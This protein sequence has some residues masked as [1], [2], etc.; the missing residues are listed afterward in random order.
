MS[1]DA[2]IVC[3]GPSA[4]LFQRWGNL[5]PVC[6]VNRGSVILDQKGYAYEWVCMMDGHGLPQFNPKPT[7]GLIQSP[8]M[9]EQWKD[10]WPNY[11]DDM[12]IYDPWR[13]RYAKDAGFT[14]WSATCAV[15]CMIAMGY[16]NILTYGMDWSSDDWDGTPGFGRHDSRWHSERSIINE[17]LR[18]NPQATVR[19]VRP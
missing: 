16:N 17:V 15:A 7:V 1:P 19:R 18:G 2:I 9:L 11:R 13:A 14:C 10:K 12:E 8:K 4:D 3:S 6:A 5:T